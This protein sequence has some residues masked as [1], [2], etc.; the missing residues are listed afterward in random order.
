LKFARDRKNR[1]V[2]LSQPAYIEQILDHFGMSDCRPLATPMVPN[3]HLE[4]VGTPI[5]VPIETYQKLIGS[6]MWLMLATRPD[7]SFSVGQLSRYTASPTQ[8]HWIAALTVLR[9]L[10]GTYEVGIIFNGKHD[11]KL[12]GYSDANWAGS[13]ADARSTTGYI[14]YYGGPISWASIRQSNVA[15]STTEAEYMAACEATREALYLKSV[16][17]SLDSSTVTSA[18]EIHATQRDS[19]PMELF[20]DNQGAIKLSN[21][22]AFHRRTKHINTRYHFIREKVANKTLKLTYVPTQRML[23]DM[24]TKSLPRPQLIE[25]SKLIGLTRS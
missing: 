3:T 14:F 10:K 8:E 5:K 18:P 12:L 16:I 11:K 24:F 15:L 25:H 4:P 21:N 7:L 17:D 22:P 1:T 2:T 23:A 20:C 9:Y 19:S 6:L 13:Y